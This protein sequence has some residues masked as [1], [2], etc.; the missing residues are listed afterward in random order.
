MENTLEMLFGYV[1]KIAYHDDESGFTVARLK[2][3]RQ[4][5]LVTAV[6]VLP[7]VQ[8][9]EKV[10][11]K[12]VWK[13]NATHGRQFE[14]KECLVE[15]PTDLEGIKKYLSSGLVKGIGP[16]YAAK[17]VE[18]FGLKTLEVIDQS[19]DEL[20][21]VEG[22]GAKKVEKIK[23]SWGAQKKIRHLMFFFQ[24]IGVTAGY[25]QRIYRGYGD[26]AIEKIEDNPY[27][28]ARDIG[29]IGFKM[30]DAIADKMGFEK[31]SEKRVIA[32]IEYAL[33]ELASEGHVCYPLPPFL[34]KAK[35]MLGADAAQ[36]EE[37]IGALV[38]EGRVFKE[39]IGAEVF[40]WQKSLYL[41]EKGVARQL[42]RIAHGVCRLR[43]FDVDKALA[44]A[45]ETLHIKLA[46]EQGE[47]VRAALVEKVHIITGGPG[48]GKS[49]ITKAILAITAKLTPHILLAAPTG[50]AA[51]RMSEITKRAAFTIHSLL[52]Y[53]FKKKGFKRDSEN[54]LVCDLLIVDE[55]SMIDTFLMYHLLKAVPQHTRLLLVGDVHQLPSV[56]A[57]NVLKDMIESNQITVTRL[58]KI[59]R[60]AA[61]SKIITNAHKINEGLFPDLTQG[62]SSDF[63]FMAAQTENEVLTHVSELLTKRLPQEHHFHPIDDV[64]VLAPMKRGLIGTENLNHTLQ[65]L[66]NPSQEAVQRGGHRFA[67]NDKVMQMRNNYNKEVYNGDIGRVTAIDR[68]EEELTITFDGKMVVYRFDELEEVTLAYATSIH[69]YQGSEC[70]CVIIPF[71]TSHYI[72][73]HRNLLYTAVTRGKKLVIIVGSPKAI[74]IAVSNDKIKERYSALNSRLQDAISSK[75][76]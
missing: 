20:L 36:I 50:R 6:G 11:C 22:I 26:Q 12:G 28:L 13:H 69:K 66:L 74:A 7:L 47:A 73:L 40:V 14:V 39:S 59:F 16:A 2:L 21:D 65:K 41:A 75:A 61:G 29:G 56:G 76:P 37:K 38:E 63:L 55:A 30:A 62:E 17:I 3:P 32:G 25:V 44:W 60:Q 33:M 23:E 51:K 54:P 27:N 52:Q 15:A 31:G 19:T 71:H 67:L 48:T 68:E 8:P 53:D 57:G 10:H 5:D 70:P 34:E 9:G 18:R 64:Q 42:S 43:S 49:T 4:K 72:M 46:P 45:E 1:E 58:R 35:E 24:K